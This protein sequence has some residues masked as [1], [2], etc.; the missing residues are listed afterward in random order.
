MALKLNNVFFVIKVK[1]ILISFNKNNG[2]LAAHP[3]ARLV[4]GI[5]VGTGSLGHG[6]SI[7]LGIALSAI[8]KELNYKVFVIVGDGELNEG[9]IWESV[10]FSA[11]NNLNNLKV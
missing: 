9:M 2:R 4:P 5:E 8:I 10:L 7:G 1:L 11:Q 6:F 3:P